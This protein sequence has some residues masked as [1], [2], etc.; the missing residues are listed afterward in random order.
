[1]NKIDLVYNLISPYIKKTPIQ[2]C[3][4]LSKLYNAKIFLKREDLQI[5]RSFKIRGALNKILNCNNTKNV[6]CASAGNHAQGVGY[7]C[8]LLYLGAFKLLL[9]SLKRRDIYR[10][11]ISKRNGISRFQSLH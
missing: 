8:D 9:N 3:D 6:V 5:T 4:R 7:V 2:F 11:K 1:M 10:F